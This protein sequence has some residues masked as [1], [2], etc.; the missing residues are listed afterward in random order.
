[1]VDD[2][3]GEEYLEHAQAGHGSQRMLSQHR[4]PDQGEQERKLERTVKNKNT[5]CL[6]WKTLRE[7][8]HKT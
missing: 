1:V 8:I 2:V 5:I 6:I 4:Y 3:A 7:N